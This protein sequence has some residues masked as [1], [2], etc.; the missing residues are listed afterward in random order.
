MFFVGIVAINEQD[1]K[2]Q[3]EELV[4]RKKW[5]CIKINVMLMF[6]IFF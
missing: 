3:A 4:I 1:F 2:K 5:Y 6:V